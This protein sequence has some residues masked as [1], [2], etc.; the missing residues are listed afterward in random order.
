[1]G[2][3]GMEEEKKLEMIRG[4]DPAKLLNIR[5]VSPSGGTPGL[6]DVTAD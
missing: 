1:M 3:G 2:M 5:K 6:T 4:M